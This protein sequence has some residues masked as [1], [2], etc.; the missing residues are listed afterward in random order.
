VRVR[1]R[2]RVRVGVC[3]CVCVCTC[4]C[5]CQERGLKVIW[6]NLKICAYCDSLGEQL[7]LTP[8]YKGWEECGVSGN[9]SQVTF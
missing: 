7:I 6:H 5:V 4:V 9:A 3:V 8:L 2:V 1:V